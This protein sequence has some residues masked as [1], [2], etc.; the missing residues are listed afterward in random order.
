MRVL[1]VI[2]IA[3]FA[4]ACARGAPVQD[5]PIIAREPTTSA[6]ISAASPTSSAPLPPYEAAERYEILDITISRYAD[7]DWRRDTS[8]SWLS[9]SDLQNSLNQGTLSTEVE[10]NEELGDSLHIRFVGADP[11]ARNSPLV[12]RGPGLR[13]GAVTPGRF[14][15]ASDDTEAS[16]SIE[17]FMGEQ[18]AAA[19]C[20][21][22]R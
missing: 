20:C 8:G 5:T 2:L 15:A 1:I 7:H 6:A 22:S 9:I 3:S 19:C 14:E 4:A 12:L 18:R 17:L 11:A 21:R 13:P 10:R 16:L